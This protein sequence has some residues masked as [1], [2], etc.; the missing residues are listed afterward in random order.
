SYR[1]TILGNTKAQN[2]L[3]VLLNIISN[4]LLRVFN[5]TEHIRVW[6]SPVLSDLSKDS[7]YIFFAVSLLFMAFASGLPA[8]FAMS[9]IEDNKMK[10]RSQL[11]ISGLFSS[12]YWLGH[13]LVDVTLYWILLFLMTSI[14][15]A[16]NYN[17]I[18][19]FWTVVLLI[20]C[21][22]GN[23]A[24]LVLCVYIISF[25]F[26]RGKSHHDSWSFFFVM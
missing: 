6:N 22:I 2:G 23:G 10:A 17:I 12:A 11:R 14:L 1:F 4:A 20:V 16:L 5:S 21:I 7:H 9:S 25:I 26:G 24:A 15:F 3:P 8:H 13:A 19:D 18:V